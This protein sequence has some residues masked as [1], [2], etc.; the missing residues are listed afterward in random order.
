MDCFILTYNTLMQLFLQVN[1]LVFFTLLHPVN[2]N[3]CPATY[4]IGNVIR[5]DFFLNQ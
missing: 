4:N 5:I 3:T 1:E 2:R